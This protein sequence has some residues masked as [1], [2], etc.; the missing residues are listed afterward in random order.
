[1]KILEKKDKNTSKK[2]LSI[3]ISKVLEN[4]N[5]YYFD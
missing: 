4:K 2:K 1:M 3:T 5:K